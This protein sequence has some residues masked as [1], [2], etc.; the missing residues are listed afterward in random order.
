M[1]GLMGDIK[2]AASDK[3]GKDSQPGDGVERT[4]DQGINQEVNQFASDHGVPQSAD[5][6]IDQAVDSK[7]ND[8]IPGGN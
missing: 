3:L 5:N 6:T 7:V 1:S 2:N 4:A 8:E